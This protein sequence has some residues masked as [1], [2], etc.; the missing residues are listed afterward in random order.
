MPFITR[1]LVK[2]TWVLKARPSAPKGKETDCVKQ[3]P[4]QEGGRVKMQDKMVENKEADDQDGKADG[5]LVSHA[6][7]VA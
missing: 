4:H 7:C 6:I 3:A 1:C 5:N 2:K